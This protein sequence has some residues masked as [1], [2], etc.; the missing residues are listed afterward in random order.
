MIFLCAHNAPP[1]QFGPGDIYKMT[2]DPILS[3][4]WSGVTHALIPDHPLHAAYSRGLVSTQDA[5]FMY[6]KC[7]EHSDGILNPLEALC[8]REWRAVEP[9]S[10]IVD[11]FVFSNRK[12]N[13]RFWAGVA[14]ARV[15]FDV[16]V[17]GKRLSVSG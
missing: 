5:M 13:P 14:L 7:L 3:V 10:S 12:A 16:V 17:D 9:G 2:T 11:G 8:A 15:G 6:L 4:G 1:E